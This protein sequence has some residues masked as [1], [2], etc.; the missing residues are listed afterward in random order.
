[1]YQCEDC[2]T[3][4][5]EEQLCT[6]TEPHGEQFFCCPRC[7]GDIQKVKVCEWCNELYL[8]ENIDDGVCIKCQNELI[9]ALTGLLNDRFSDYE[10]EW[11]KDNDYINLD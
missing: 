9:S 2:L 10:L 8:E 1:M 7:K 4:I 6:Y 11:L 5:E 3:Y